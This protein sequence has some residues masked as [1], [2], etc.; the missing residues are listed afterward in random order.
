LGIYGKFVKLADKYMLL[1]ELRGDLLD[2]TPNANNYLKQLGTQTVAVDNPY[3][4]PKPFY[5]VIINCNDALKNFNIMR[6]KKLLDNTQYYQRY[7]DILF[8]RS[9]LYLQLGHSLWHCA[10]CNRCFNYHC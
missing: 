1:N 7:T 8:L 10:L 2:V 5:E 9:W 3:A 4:D 6:D